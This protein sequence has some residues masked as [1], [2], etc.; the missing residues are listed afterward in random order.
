MRVP[1]S[2]LRE[3]VE[4]PATDDVDAIGVRL[5][6]AG[7]EIEDI[8][9]VGDIQGPLVVGRVVS[10]DDEEQSNGKSIRWCQVDVGEDNGGV[11]GI[12]C[13]ASNFVAGDLVIAALP[14]A[15]LPGGF[16]IAARKTYGH[17]S[18]GMLC[19]GKE[20]GLGDDH[21]GIMIVE[22]TTAVGSNAQ[23]IIG[24]ADQVFD[25][26]VTPDRGYCFSMR[27][28]ARELSIAYASTF[29]D[30]ASASLPTVT[31]GDRAG[32]DDGADRIII[33]ELAGFNPAAVSPDWLQL[34]LR[35]LGMRPISLAV[36]VTN[37]VML[38]TGQPLHAFDSA[39]VS[40]AL[41]VR[42]A[43]QG[44]TLTTLD[45][46]ERQLDTDDVVIADDSGAV[47][48][49]GTMGGASTEVDGT[50]TGILLEAA[51]FDSVAIARQSRRHK[52]S[53]EA[54]KRFERGTDPQL[55][56]AAAAVAIALLV[57]HGGA[58]LVSVS[59]VDQRPATTAIAFDLQRPTRTA[60]IEIAD[61]F[62]ID[63]LTSVGCIVEGSQA[64]VAVTPPSWRPDL[65]DPADLDEEVIR[66]FGYDNVPSRLPRLP[67][68]RGLT[69]AQ[70]IRR[71]I[72]QT[73][74]NSGH[75]E[76]LAYP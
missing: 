35:L 2:W 19:S 24:Q 55:P 76:V 68:G 29:T 5:V 8:E 63:A 48:L 60:G 67:S 50:T 59:E 73:L 54:S 62:A 40:G 30:P 41:R 13:G 58:T 51:H 69:A 7:L 65:T 75:I 57:E 72:A 11:R 12:V 4:I 42:R 45:D 66:L 61:S 43:L 47:A 44:E 25:L 21:S 74:A 17:V 20:L 28:V 37:Y 33:S 34:R 49:A 36:D 1:V 10:F 38:L 3:L 16:A 64:V 23:D 15:V 52:L 31:A 71:T 46:V 39:K 26:A 6:S 9:V 70:R 18:D 56:A 32:I 14:G 27:G 22:A 53:S